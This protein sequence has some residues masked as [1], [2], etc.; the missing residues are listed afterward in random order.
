MFLF[1]FLRENTSV[2]GSPF[3]V[4]GEPL[5]VTV[6]IGGIIDKRIKDLQDLYRK[7]MKLCERRIAKT[8]MASGILFKIKQSSIFFLYKFCM[9]FYIKSS[10]AALIS[11]TSV[12]LQLL[13]IKDGSNK[14]LISFSA[15]LFSSANLR[16]SSF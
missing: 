10:S 7:H 11:S 3:R 14:S 13:F 8:I 16:A 1:I 6:G 15:F 5:K 9:H 12:S 4:E 2:E